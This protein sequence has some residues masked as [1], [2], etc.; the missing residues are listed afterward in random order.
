MTPSLTQTLMSELLGG[1][2]SQ[3]ARAVVGEGQTPTPTPATPPMPAG[4]P[5]APKRWRTLRTPDGQRPSPRQAQRDAR[6]YAEAWYQALKAWRVVVP[7]VL[8]PVIRYGGGWSDPITTMGDGAPDRPS[9]LELPSGTA[10]EVEVG[11]LISTWAASPIPAQRELGQLLHGLRSGRGMNSLI[12]HSGRG[13]ADPS[14]RA[15]TYAVAVLTLAV[16]LGDQEA[17]AQLQH[18]VFARTSA[19]LSVSSTE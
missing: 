16:N 3:E 4:E 5:Q 18:L 17:D 12:H 10:R 8:T 11:R 13:W 14:E 15:Q 19:T 2:T 1:Q 9:G 6:Q 7:P